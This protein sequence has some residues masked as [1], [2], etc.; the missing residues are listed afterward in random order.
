MQE[1]LSLISPRR[2]Q[3]ETLW[4]PVEQRELLLAP[5]L[6]SSCASLCWTRAIGLLDP[7]MALELRQSISP[8]S[9]RVECDLALLSRDA[10]PADAPHAALLLRLISSLLSPAASLGVERVP[11]VGAARRTIAP[12]GLDW[13]GDSDPARELGTQARRLGVAFLPAPF[14]PFDVA[15]A[16]SVLAACGGGALIIRL[17]RLPVYD[18][19]SEGFAALER[20]LFAARDKRVPV[21]GLDRLV[22]CAAALKATNQL[23]RLELSVESAVADPVAD[24]FVSLA[25]FG[26]RVG[27]PGSLVAS[28]LRGLVVTGLAPRQLLCSENTLSVGGGSGSAPY[29]DG[30]VEIGATPDGTPIFIGA[31]SRMRHTYVIGGTGTG[32]S[33]LLRRMINQDVAAGDC[34]VLLDPHG[35]LS[36]E[37][38]ELLKDNRAA[39]VHMADASDPQ[40]SYALDLLSPVRNPATREQA[41]DA[42]MSAFKAVL[43]SDVK[44]AFGP[45][46]EQYFRYSLFL[47][48]LGGCNDDTLAELP[49][50][51]TDPAFRKMLQVAAQDPDL[52]RFWDKIA[53]RSSGDQ[54]LENFTPYIISK[55]TRMIGSPLAKRLF[56]RNELGIDLAK[57]IQPGHVLILRL[58]KGDLG[59]TTTQLAAAMTLTQ[60]A[61]AIMARPVGNR[62]PVR[63]YIDEV[64]AC[65]G[66]TI[67]MLLAECRKFGASLTLA[68]QSLGQVGSSKA[69]SLGSAVLAN[70]ANL[71]LFRV[72]APDAMALSPWLEEPENWRELVRLPDYHLRARLVDSGCPKV[73]PL[74]RTASLPN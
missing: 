34:V 72:G 23:F 71:L 47:L 22:E 14:W 69:G 59:E 11:V 49:R 67:A 28:D 24:D 68:N 40:G 17:S 57:H 73:V 16:L 2:E 33:T 61:N 30:D 26:T 3:V 53:T 64:Q 42:F 6:A 63:L 27:G 13:I 74:V 60:L 29:S 4:T 46:F 9:G 35:D 37:V 58:P 65:P 1:H 5:S 7:S 38:A 12:A 70:V 45:L 48:A 44:E 52:D 15:R 39:K 8:G 36:L 32:K 56:C 25:M 50:I 41:Y 20:L 54:A 66:N 21:R 43:Y 51:F 10:E 18:R 31:Q 62:P 19:P 55:L